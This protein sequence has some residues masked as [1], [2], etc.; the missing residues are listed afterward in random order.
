[1]NHH[2]H[3]FIWGLL[4]SAAPWN[5]VNYQHFLFVHETCKSIPR[6]TI[7]E[8][9]TGQN[10]MSGRVGEWRKL[11]ESQQLLWLR[12]NLCWKCSWGGRAAVQML[13]AP[14]VEP[15]EAAGAWGPAP[16]SQLAPC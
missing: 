9:E 14:G 8:Q 11:F 15:G 1:M 10:K 16:A 5:Y 12:E 3:N 13:S 4:F 7:S 2:L 6:K